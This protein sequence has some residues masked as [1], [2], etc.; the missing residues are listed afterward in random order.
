M[1][2]MLLKILHE[3]WLPTLLFGLG[4]FLIKA[5]LTHVLPQVV[6]GMG[7]IFEQFPIAKTFLTALLGTEVGEQ[8]TART[9]QAFLWVHPV[10]LALLW[11]HEI[12]LGT[13]MPAGEIDRGT[14]DVLLSWPVSRRRIY[15]C[16][17]LVWLASGI[18][19]IGL[20]Y[21]GHRSTVSTMPVTMRPEWSRAAMVMANLLCV[22][23]AIG[24]IVL[25]VS[26][27]SDRRGRAV[28]VVFALV[29]ASFLLNFLAQFWWLAKRVAFL[30]VMQYY[31][32]AKILS[33][34]VFPWHDAIV[35]LMVGTTAWV[36]GCE[37][38]ARRNICTL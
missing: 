11:G 28:A 8:I 22:Y 38:F 17:S 27:L 3:V 21:L 2:G 25:L 7:E 12:T 20:G 10:V 14:I 36:L 19:L 30:S 24:G 9:M 33:S 16:E 23:V 32:P 31:Q 13:R 1:R 4:L 26:A 5:L 35:L 18:L 29:L 15:L 37:I 34:G 6:Q